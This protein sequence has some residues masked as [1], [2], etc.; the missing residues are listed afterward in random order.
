M[1]TNEEAHSSTV[2]PAAPVASRLFLGASRM[3]V[4]WLP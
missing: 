4:T 1:A 2:T 3:V